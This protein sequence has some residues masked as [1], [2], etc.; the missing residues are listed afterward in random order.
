MHYG[1]KKIKKKRAKRVRIVGEVVPL[2]YVKQVSWAGVVRLVKRGIVKT[3]MV[4]RE[5]V[6][7]SDDIPRE[8][9]SDRMNAHDCHQ[10]AV[11]LNLP[12]ARGRESGEARVRR[13][14]RGGV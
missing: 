5:G 11:D 7:F 3:L 8:K 10:K 14:N 13:L 4:P 2:G 1:D 12:W 9:G 6:K